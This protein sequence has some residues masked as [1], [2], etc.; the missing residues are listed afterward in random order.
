MQADEMLLW[1]LVGKVNVVFANG[2]AWTRY[3]RVVKSA[4]SRNLPIDQFVSLGNKLFKKMG[5]G[6][7]IKWDE[8]SLVSLALLIV[9]QLIFDENHFSS[10]LRLMRWVGLMSLRLG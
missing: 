3:S 9:Y 4:L 2:E 6:G 7:F 10:V 8:Y 1:R 5:K